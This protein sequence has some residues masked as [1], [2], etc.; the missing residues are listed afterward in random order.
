ML[1]IFGAGEG[2]RQGWPLIQ[3]L[4]SQSYVS[5]FGLVSSDSWAFFLQL[6]AGIKI[7]YWPN[8]PTGRKGKGEQ[9]KH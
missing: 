1:K 7:E 5:N 2:G 6:F 4:Q 8:R 9:K 3:S